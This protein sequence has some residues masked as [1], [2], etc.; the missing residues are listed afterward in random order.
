MIEN[1]PTTLDFSESKINQD[2]TPADKIQFFR[3][4]ARIRRFEQTALKFYNKGMMGGFLHLYIGQESVAAGTLGLCK[5][6]T[7]PLPHTVVMGMHSPWV[8][9]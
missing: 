7:M 4:M 8:W 3:D 1:T 2:L 6:M 5:E 9:I